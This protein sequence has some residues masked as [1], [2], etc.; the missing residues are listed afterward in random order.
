MDFMCVSSSHLSP[1]SSIGWLAA[2]LL[3]LVRQDSRP[4][5]MFT[6]L[7]VINC[8]AGEEIWKHNMQKEVTAC[9]WFSFIT[10]SNSTLLYFII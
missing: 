3:C 1:K 6:R 9:N 8:K 10:I 2:S 4:K 7:P 5:E